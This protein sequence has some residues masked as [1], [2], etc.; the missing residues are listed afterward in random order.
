[1]IVLTRRD[2]KKEP[3]QIISIR[4]APEL[5]SKIDQL[6]DESKSNRS[7]VITEVLE[8]VVPKIKVV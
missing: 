1:M 8:K 7:A 5:I 2:E 3:K 4:L 6:A